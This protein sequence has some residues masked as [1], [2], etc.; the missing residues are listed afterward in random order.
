MLMFDVLLS[1][2]LSV[3]T[4]NRRLSTSG[5]IKA[6]QFRQSLPDIMHKFELASD[7]YFFLWPDGLIEL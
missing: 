7:I 2:A 5:R 3:C 4:I 1:S 6:S